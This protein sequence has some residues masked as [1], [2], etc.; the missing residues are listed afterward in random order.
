MLSRLF[1]GAVE[2]GDDDTTRRALGET[3]HAVGERLGSDDQAKRK[4]PPARRD[5]IRL[6]AGLGFEPYT[7]RAEIRLRNCPFDVLAAEHRELVCST[8]LCMMEGMLRGL[9]V[10]GIEARLDPVP[11]RCCVVFHQRSA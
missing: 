6:L 2:K 7:D 1:A 5:V 10:A 3:A 4:R 9:K 8:N 11:D